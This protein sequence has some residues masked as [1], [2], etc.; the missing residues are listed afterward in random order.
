[1]SKNLSFDE[2]SR[3]NFLKSSSILGGL[4]FFAPIAK[5]F[6]KSK[7][8]IDLSDLSGELRFVHTAGLNGQ[9]ES[10]S[11]GRY[12]GLN[13]IAESLAEAAFLGLKIDAGNF[14]DPNQSF[15]AHLE[16]VERLTTY[17]L[18]VAGLGSTELDLSATQLLEITEKA[19]FPLL[20]SN[21]QFENSE[22]DDA[23]L[24]HLIVNFGKYKLGVIAVADDF[25]TI[26]KK[27]KNPIQTALRESE[28]L[29]S[30]H[31]CDLVVC[32]VNFESK[33]DKNFSVIN[34]LAEKAEH[35][36]FILDTNTTNER[37]GLKLI[38]DQSGDDVMISRVLDFGNFLG[39]YSVSFTPK[40]TKY[41]VSN[42]S[43]IPGLNNPHL[44]SSFILELSTITI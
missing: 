6:S 10:S 17:G 31:A 11:K 26:P 24:K 14:L 13:S 2:K 34:R 27:V 41:L 23:V 44:A 12:G 15:A 7:N 33:T 9:L 36:D 20:N 5:T 39:D 25:G 21:Y 8:S 43:R 30:I 18:H 32:L 19:S 3:R 1:M 37:P 35:I 16:F 40:Y 4:A 28:L 29:K 22:L 38:K 42:Y